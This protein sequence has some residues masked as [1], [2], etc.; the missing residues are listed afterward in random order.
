MTR[1]L[2]E[3][4]TRQAECS[5]DATAVVMGRE[6]L[7]YGRLETLS[8]QIA[9]ALRAAGCERGDRVCLLLPKSPTTVASMLGVL[10]AD[11]CYV[12]LDTASPA[13][14]L[15]KIVDSAEPRVLLASTRGAAPLKALL[16]HDVRLNLVADRFPKGIEDH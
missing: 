16:E 9:H 10:K 2:Q 15:A 12:P 3:W 13:P 1:L 6:R 7:T 11:A 14:R 8:N 5:P 4:L